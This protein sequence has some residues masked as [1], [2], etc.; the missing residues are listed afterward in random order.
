MTTRAKNVNV[1]LLIRW[2][3]SVCFG[4]NKTELAQTMKV[5]DKCDVYSFGVVALEV[6]MGRHPGEMLESIYTASRELSND[7]EMLLKDVLDQRLEAPAGESAEA[8]VFFVAVA[9]MCA[10]PNPDR[11]PEMRFVAQEL[12]ARAQPC[13]VKPFASVT[14]NQ[15]AGQGTPRRRS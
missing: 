1:K 4:V 5:T 13:V 9:L 6:M 15:L 11:R 14:I 2:G 3:D 7:N 10:Q 12:S 8:V